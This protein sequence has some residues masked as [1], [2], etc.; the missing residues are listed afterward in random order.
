MAK[1]IIHYSFKK[2]FNCVTLADSKAIKAEIMEILGDVTIARF[3]QVRRDYPNIPAHIKQE[4][5]EIFL[6][7]G[8]SESEIW[9]MWE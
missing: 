5:E 9:D 7:Y 8:V 2:A 6:R 4:I 1:R 3:Y